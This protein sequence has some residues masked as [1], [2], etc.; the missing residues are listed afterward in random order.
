MDFEMTRGNKATARCKKVSSWGSPLY[1]DCGCQTPREEDTFDL[2][3]LSARRVKSF[4]TYTALIR[5]GEIVGSVDFAR[6][7]VSLDGNEYLGVK[8]GSK[9]ASVFKL[10]VEGAEAEGAVTAGSTT[11][12]TAATVRMAEE[13]ELAE[14][15]ER[16]KKHPGWCSKCHSYCYGD[17]ES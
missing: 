5:N 3:G 14:M 16:N 13:I 1:C 17:C 10:P 2:T 12:E 8:P 4:Q 9:L 15:D 6:D 11:E 7:Y